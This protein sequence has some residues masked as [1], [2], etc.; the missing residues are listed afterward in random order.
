VV[1]SWRAVAVTT[2]KRR[3]GTVRKTR[4]QGT[5]GVESRYEKIG[6]DIQLVA[7]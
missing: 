2:W 3:P 4:T 7:S 1:Q 5:S 6:I